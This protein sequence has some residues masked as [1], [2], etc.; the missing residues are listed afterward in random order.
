M[1]K[2]V[3]DRLAPKSTTPDLAG[4]DALLS[5]YT[6]TVPWESVFRIVKKANS[7]ELADCPRWP[8]EFWRDNLERGGGGTCFESNYAFYALLLGLE[9]EGYLTINNMGDSI[10]CHT[11]IVIIL[12]GEKWLV[13]AGLPLHT[14]IP[15]DPGRVTQRKSPFFLYTVT[16]E[17]QNVFRVDRSPHPL[18]YAF[19]LV[20]RPVTR[21]TYRASTVKDYDQN[22]H[23]L[24]RVIVNRVVGDRLWR[25]NAGEKPWRLDSFVWGERSQHPIMGRPAPAVARRFQMDEKMIEMALAVTEPTP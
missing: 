2:A 5:A 25:F 6:R 20:D 10:G 9:F 7:A 13:D 18:P 16:P 22:G 1:M 14:P 15:L 21:S 8:D 12:E 19:T 17:A 11:A 4:L 23:F 24:D 3:L